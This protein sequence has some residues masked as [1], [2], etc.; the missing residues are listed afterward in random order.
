[1]F[2]VLRQKEARLPGPQLCANAREFSSR[3]ID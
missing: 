1:M 2:T 3:V